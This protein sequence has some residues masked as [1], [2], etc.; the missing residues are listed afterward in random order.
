MPT[1]AAAHHYSLNTKNV[2]LTPKPRSKT[3]C[4]V[5]TAPDPVKAKRFTTVVR[6]KC[7]TAHLAVFFNY[8]EGTPFSTDFFSAPAGSW[9][10]AGVPIQ[11]VGVYRYTVYLFP[12]GGGPMLK[13]DPQVVV[14]DERG[15][16][17]SDTPPPSAKG[18]KD[19]A[20]AIR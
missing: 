5:K 1:R 6:W 14:W 20:M 12:V 17:S 16:S 11:P 9:A 10:S 7:A 2:T 3:R 13:C 4:K 18:R 15:G 19:P 8:A